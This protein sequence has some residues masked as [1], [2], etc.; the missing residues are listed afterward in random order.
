MMRSK[1]LVPIIN[2]PG[3]VYPT[4]PVCGFSQGRGTSC[5]I[6]NPHLNV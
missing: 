6:H 2:E 3:L 5:P 1:E 4:P